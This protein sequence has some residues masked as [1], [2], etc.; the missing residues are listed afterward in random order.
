MSVSISKYFIIYAQP[1]RSSDIW[2]KEWTIDELMDAPGTS[3]IEELDIMKSGKLT[4][5]HESP[6][7]R[8]FKCLC[9]ARL[10]KPVA[11]RE[12]QFGQLN[13]EIWQQ[14]RGGIVASLEANKNV[15]RCATNLL[16]WAI[17]RDPFAIRPVRIM[18]SDFIQL[19]RHVME[20]LGGEVTQVNL[21]KIKSTEVNLRQFYLKGSHL[22]R[23]QNFDEYIERS[24]DIKSMGFVI[25]ARKEFRRIS[26]RIKYWGGG[27]IYS[28]SDPLDH[29]ILGFLDMLDRLFVSGPVKG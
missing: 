29:E 15:S 12:A 16:S 9:E 28:P 6:L 26:F 24:G 11:A 27:Q 8:V 1:N 21:G 25:P 3:R 23:L 19:K 4:L 17:Y 2:K 5:I 14:K 13:F 10:R 7:H 22:E 18:K 20:N